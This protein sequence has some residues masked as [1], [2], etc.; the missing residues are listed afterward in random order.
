[1]CRALLH[2][3]EELKGDLDLLWSCDEH[4]APKLAAAFGEVD[5]TVTDQDGAAIG[6]GVNAFA[7]PKV[8]FSSQGSS[9]D[10]CTPHL[11]WGEL[12]V[13]GVINRAHVTGS[14]GLTIQYASVADP[15]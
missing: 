12:D 8:V 10:C 5:A 14:E 9:G 11:P 2:G 7:L 4:E 3:S 13:V 6:L 15:T 1:M